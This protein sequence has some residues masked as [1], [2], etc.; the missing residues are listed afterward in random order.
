MLQQFEYEARLFAVGGKTSADGAWLR[1]QLD[2]PTG[3]PAQRV[4]G[5]VAHP[6][7]D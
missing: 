3:S 2:M 4:D 7:G 6:R 1:E 5:A